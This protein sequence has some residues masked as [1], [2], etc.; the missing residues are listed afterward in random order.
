[1]FPFSVYP[2]RFFGKGQRIDTVNR[3]G[4][5]AGPKTFVVNHL[6]V[7]GMLNCFF[8]TFRTYCRSDSS[9]Y[10]MNPNCCQRHDKAR[11]LYTAIKVVLRG[12]REIL[13]DATKPLALWRTALRMLSHSRFR[14]SQVLCQ[15]NSHPFWG[16]YFF[17]GEREI[18]T[19]APV[20]RPTPLAGAPLH[21]LEY[22]STR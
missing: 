6:A 22:F 2:M 5:L 21:Q 1:M 16:G 8:I 3:S 9:H 12:E 11:F 15:K 4:F 20:S 19:L 18:R 17:G 10:S 7:N 14:S 13:A